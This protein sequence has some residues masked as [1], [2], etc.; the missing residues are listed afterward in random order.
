MLRRVV[1]E[2]VLEEVAIVDVVDAV[3]DTDGETVEDGA[4][5]EDV[6]SGRDATAN[7]L[8]ITV[9]KE[10]KPEGVIVIWSARTPATLGAIE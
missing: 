2:C 4:D 5:G 1:E 9:A 7:V 3:T 8:T 10:V 6:E